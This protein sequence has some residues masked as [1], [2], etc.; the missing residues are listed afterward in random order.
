[1]SIRMIRLTFEP[2]FFE[3]EPFPTKES[4]FRVQLRASDKSELS[5]YETESSEGAFALVVRVGRVVAE[6]NDERKKFGR[7]FEEGERESAGC[8]DLWRSK[9]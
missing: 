8:S 7:E 5:V 2:I 4:G 1:M 6:S 9:A 3:P